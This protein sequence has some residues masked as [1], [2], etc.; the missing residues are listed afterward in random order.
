M[1]RDTSKTPVPQEV[2]IQPLAIN[3]E[4]FK[5]DEIKDAKVRNRINKAWRALDGL[6]AIGRI[7]E[8]NHAEQIAQ[9]DPLVLDS[10]AVSGLLSAVVA[11]AEIGRAEIDNCG[12]HI[13]AETKAGA[14]VNR[15]GV[16]DVH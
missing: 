13:V 8:A 2:T 4:R 12:E 6:S 7:L 14:E 15:G 10:R 9:D 3:Y 11:L 5:D 16:H 1:P